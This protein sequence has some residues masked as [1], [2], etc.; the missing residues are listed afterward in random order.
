[1]SLDVLHSIIH[2][3]VADYGFRLAV[4]WGADD[5][6]ARLELTVEEAEILKSRIIPE[7]NQLPDP[8][9]PSDQLGVQE[10]LKKLSLAD[11][12]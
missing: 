3:A 1:M 11:G 10:R 9:E 6:I 4:T 7:L 5:I 12:E 8:V 2:R